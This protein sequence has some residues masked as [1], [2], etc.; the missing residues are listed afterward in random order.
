MLLVCSLV[1]RCSS[2]QRISCN[3]SLI[4]PDHIFK[5]SFHL[6]SPFSHC[7][8]R[9][10]LINC[11]YT[12]GHVVRIILICPVYAISSVIAL[13][14][15]NNGLYAEIF[16]DLY[17]AFVVYCFMYLMLEYC[18]GETD[19]IYMMENEPPLRLPFPFSCITRPRNARYTCVHC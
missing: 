9:M 14:L 10:Q 3:T 7:I 12:P 6:P 15:G 16:R 5:V 18:G 13:L 17:E 8:C 19:C 4:S 11:L 2:V 1:C